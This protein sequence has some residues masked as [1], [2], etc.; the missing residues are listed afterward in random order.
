MGLGGGE[1]NLPGSPCL[2][3]AGAPSRLRLWQPAL[4]LGLLPS[5]CCKE[6]VVQ[7]GGW[8]QVPRGWRG[9]GAWWHAEHL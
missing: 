5:A 1:R 4:A 9:P 2:A 6:P 7:P 8:L 3:A